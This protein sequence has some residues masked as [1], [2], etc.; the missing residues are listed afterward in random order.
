MAGYD[1]ENCRMFRITD[2]GERQQMASFE[3][4]ITEEIRFIDGKF[5]E[6]W[7]TICGKQMDCDGKEKEFEPLNIRA[8]EFASMS[9]VM[10]NWGVKAVVHPGFGIK[11]DLRTAIQMRSEPKVKTIFRHMGWTQIGGK[12]V[13]LHCGGGIGQTGNDPS[14]RV[15]LPPELS[16]Y[17]IV[18]QKDVAACV[19]ATL[20]LADL[21]PKW[22]MWPMIAATL[23]PL[24]GEVDFGTHLAGRT[25]TFKSEVMSLLQSHYGAGMDARHLPG[26]WSS[27]GNALEAQSYYAKNAAF[28]IDD[29]VPAGSA[30][31]LRAYQQTA[32]KIIRAQG[33]Q[34]GRARLSD[35]A[36]MQATM[37]PRGICMSTGEDIPEGQSVRARM[38]IA[39]LS[40]GDINPAKLTAAQNNRELYQ[41]TV[42]ALAKYLSVEDIDLTE[43]T[44]EVRDQNLDLGHSR[45]PSMV[46]RL[47]ATCWAFL[48]WCEEMGYLDKSKARSLEDESYEAIKEAGNKQGHYLEGADPVELF[49]STLRHIFTA[50]LGHIRTVTGGIPRH[51]TLLGWTQES[52]ND[53]MP[54]YKSHGPGIGWIKWD[55]GELYIDETAG[56]NLIRKIAG[57]DLALTKLTLIKR[58]KD[59]A[60]LKRTDEARQRNVIRITAENHPRQVVALSIDRILDSKEIPSE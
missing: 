31:Q 59:A 54:T 49:A 46:G 43:I 41:G 53:D 28:V 44:K 55:Q 1:C 7:L 58:L 5:S 24:Y 32:D 23:T 35:T 40:P 6:T 37:Y 60:M 22:V 13:Y 3:A 29:F 17:R 39:E 9:W 14:V 21:G 20:A 18:E 42:A 27:T 4:C 45:T 33:N 16:R 48:A 30:W 25:G 57:G 19:R 10:P 56:L 11:E 52:Y 2:E 36:A 47:T 12:K 51:P 34:A 50:G 15:E 38:M 8:T 26:S